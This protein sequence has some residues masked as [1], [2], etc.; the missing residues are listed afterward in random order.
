MLNIA[1]THASVVLVIFII[2]C[3]KISNL[4]D[5]HYTVGCVICISNKVKYLDKERNLSAI[6]LKFQQ[7]SISVFHTDWMSSQWQQIFAFFNLAST[8]VSTLFVLLY[9]YRVYLY[10]GYD[11]TQR[12]G[13]VTLTLHSQVIIHA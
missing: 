4:I 3:Y 13:I 1:Y 11:I 12:I 6:S 7:I 5:T 9:T 10:V 2:I 8:L